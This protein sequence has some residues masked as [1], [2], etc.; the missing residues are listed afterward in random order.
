MQGYPPKYAELL[1]NDKKYEGIITRLTARLSVE[2]Q[3]RKAAQDTLAAANAHLR[4]ICNEAG[5][6]TSYLGD[7]LGTL[8][9]EHLRGKYY[10]QRDAEIA[11]CLTAMIHQA[12]PREV[13]SKKP[14]TSALASI[15]ELLD[16]LKRLLTKQPA[17]SSGKRG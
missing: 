3:Q 5:L 7:D 6:E 16:G 12:E 15:K 11:A 17:Q 14:L 1:D 8:I 10:A 4:S 2:E 9:C 13:V